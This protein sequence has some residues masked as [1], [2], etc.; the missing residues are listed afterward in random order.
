MCVH[1]STL[2]IWELVQISFETQNFVLLFS[3]FLHSSFSIFKP[4]SM[5]SYGDELLLDSSSPWSGVF[6]H[7]SSFSIPLSL[8]FKK[9]RTPL[10]EKIQGLQTPHGATS[11][12]LSDPQPYF[13]STVV[14]AYSIYVTITK[15]QQ[16]VNATPYGYTH[17]F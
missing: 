6:N 9:Q 5:T 15:P 8:N 16:S 1:F 4:L 11:T 3:L 13:K 10:M 17:S 2:I 7:L 14:G 12:L